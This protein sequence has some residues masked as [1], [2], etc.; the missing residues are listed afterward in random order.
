[1]PPYQ[2]LS[3]FEKHTDHFDRT[4]EH[5]IETD[6]I[7]AWMH[8]HPN[9]KKQLDEVIARSG[10]EQNNL[11]FIWLISRYS[12]PLIVF[13]PDGEIQGFIDMPFKPNDDV[14]N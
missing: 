1:M 11:H 3:L 2:I 4:L 13:S 9:S 14:W 7:S 12:N 8:E 6:K 10:F 5:E